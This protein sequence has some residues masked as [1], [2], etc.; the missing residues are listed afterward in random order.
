MFWI[1]FLTEVLLNVLVSFVLEVV[2]QLYSVTLKVQSESF[3]DELVKFLVYLGLVHIKVHDVLCSFAINHVSLF[4]LSK[5][6]SIAFH[7]N[8]EVH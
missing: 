3:S 6:I 2:Y 5:S 4:Q 8:V 7:L 1:Q